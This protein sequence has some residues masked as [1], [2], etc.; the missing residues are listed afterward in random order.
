MGHAEHT[1]GPWRAQAAARGAFGIWDGSN[2]LVGETRNTADTS[3]DRRSGSPS[4]P[5]VAK[6]NAELMAGAPDMLAAL[7]AVVSQPVKHVTDPDGSWAAIRD[8]DMNQA[9]AAIEAAER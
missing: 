5:E 3:V 7:K 8:P 6:A 9:R 2:R 1:P 4:L